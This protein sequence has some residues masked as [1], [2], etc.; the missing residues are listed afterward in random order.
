MVR[1][2]TLIGATFL[3]ALALML[4]GARVLQGR[5]GGTSLHRLVAAGQPVYCGGG[6][7]PYVALTFDDGPTRWTP[8]LLAVLKANHARAT[9][10][11]IGE[12]AARHPDWV[13]KEAEAGEVGDHSW[14]HPSLPGLG[15]R[16]V[17]DELGRTKRTIERISS[18]PVRLVRVPSGARDAIVDDV[19]ERLGLLEVL[20]NVD[21]GDAS[22]PSTPSSAVIARNLTARVRPGAIVLLHEDETVPRAIEALRIFLP[23]LRR[24]GLKPV[25]VSELL[26]LDPP[27][28]G[29]LGN[30]GGCNSS[31]SPGG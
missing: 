3:V 21:D 31:W 14:S 10:F 5:S 4:V 29:S 23:Q 16:R 17:T 19:A 2:R 28:A 30:R 24:Q 1:R 25:T 27:A 6:T 26:Q 22:A 20:W 9:F 15:R 8:L 13:R 18:G 11:E 12:K 7:G